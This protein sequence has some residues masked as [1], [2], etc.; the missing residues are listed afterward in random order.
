LFWDSLLPLLLLLLLLVLLSLLLLVLL[1]LLLSSGEEEAEDEDEDAAAARSEEEE[2]VEVDKEGRGRRGRASDDGRDELALAFTS[3]AAL[4]RVGGSNGRFFLEAAALKEE[5]QQS[6][7]ARSR[8]EAPRRGGGMLENKKRAARKR[9]CGECCRFFPSTWS[10]LFCFQSKANQF[11]AQP[12]LRT[13]LSL[14]SRQSLFS[15]F[16]LLSA[17]AM[18]SEGA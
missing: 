6:A 12:G 9:E 4:R 7:L 5:G 14:L 15:L 18:A 10:P 13:L 16:F 2:G 3:L 11:V 17:R 8:A 1:L